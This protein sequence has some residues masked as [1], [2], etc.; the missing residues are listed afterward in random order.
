[1]QIKFK[2]LHANAVIPKYAKTGDGGMDLIAT[3]Y[4]V[5]E[6]GCHCYKT[7][8]ASEFPENY[9]AL[10]FP[11]SSITKYALNLANCVGVLDSGYRGEIIL[12]FKN[13]P[14]PSSGENKI[15]NIGDKIAQLVI[16]ELPKVE[17][18]EVDNLSG[19]ERGEG[20]FGSTGK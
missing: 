10:L 17:I 16:L 11:R 13:T 19:S 14:N 8:L 1:M 6:N 12:K 20:G 15:Y 4:S 7:G 18:F 9:V 3:E 2:K 5:D